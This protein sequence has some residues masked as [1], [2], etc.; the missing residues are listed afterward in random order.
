MERLTRV[1]IADIAHKAGVSAGTVDRVIHNRGEVSPRTRQ[2]VEA[3]IREM[4]YEPDLLASTL[5]SKKTYRFA[6]L[7]PKSDHES[8]FWL[9]PAQGIEKAFKRIKHYGVAYQPYYFD[10]HNNNSFFDACNKLLEVPPDGLIMAPLFA[11]L[12]AH[13]TDR[14]VELGTAVV[15]INTHINH[16]SQ[17]AYVGQDAFRSG[18]VAA[19]LL[20]LCTC[21][22]GEL[23]IINIINQKGSSGHLMSREE[24]FLDFFAQKKS[25]HKKISTINVQARPA[26]SIHKELSENLLGMDGEIKFKG[27]FVTNSRVYQVADFLENTNKG[28]LRVVGYDLLDRSLAHLQK[29]NIDFLISQN[30]VAQGYHSFMALFDILVRKKTIEKRQYLPIDIVTR[31][32]IDY[33]LKH[34]NND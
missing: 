6:S 29:G 12:A 7:L 2:K 32:N 22:E 14:A 19:Q 15:F 9:Q 3:I 18:K 31:E 5:A 25:S 28:P 13:F 24:G 34:Q 1:R 4:H 16:S 21:C 23:G 20:D 27:L 26:V 8:L 17:R 11:D 30:P 10:Y 33:Y